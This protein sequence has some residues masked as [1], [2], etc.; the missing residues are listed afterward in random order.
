MITQTFAYMTH[1]E[2]E[3]AYITT[4]EAFIFLQVVENDPP[5]VFNHLAEPTAEVLENPDASLRTAA[6]SQVLAFT[7]RAL[8]SKRRSQGWIAAAKRMLPT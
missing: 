1:G 7:L 2:V 4:G 5:K 8:Q 3:Y 6:V